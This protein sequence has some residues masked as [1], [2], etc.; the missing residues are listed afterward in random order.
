M[1]LLNVFQM[2]SSPYLENVSLVVSTEDLPPLLLALL[3][4]GET[5]H[6]VPAP[7]IRNLEIVTH[8]NKSNSNW[9]PAASVRSL[10]RERS[11]ND[12]MPGVAS[13]K[14]LVISRHLVEGMEEWYGTAV[15]D[16]GLIIIDEPAQGELYEGDGPGREE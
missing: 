5:A 2:L 9:L 4:S 11:V 6:P 1:R 8:G 12:H 15:E 7:S 3:I 10:V 13:L 14:R 16:D